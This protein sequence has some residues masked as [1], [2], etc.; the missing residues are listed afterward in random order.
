MNDTQAEWRV[1]IGRQPRRVMRKL[2]ADVRTRVDQAIVRLAKEPRPHGCRK[3]EGHAYLWRVRVGDWRIVY[4]IKS[5][6]L[7]VLIVQISPRGEA[8]RNL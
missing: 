3:L 8:Y 4:A 2:P 5:D 7:V 1:V 6:R